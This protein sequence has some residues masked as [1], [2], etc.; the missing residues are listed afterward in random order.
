M[1]CPPDE[2]LLRRR[3]RWLPDRRC[4]SDGRPD[5]GVFLG[6]VVFRRRCRRFHIVAFSQSE[7]SSS[8]VPLSPVV[9][10]VL[11]VCHVSLGRAPSYLS[12]VMLR[13]C[14]RLSTVRRRVEMEEY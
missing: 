5:T 7:P 2:P 9:M 4:R 1:C 8:V 3:V 12:I 10:F 6:Y 11:Y 13:H 14:R